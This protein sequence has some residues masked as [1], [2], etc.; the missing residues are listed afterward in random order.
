MR[1]SKLPLQDI[2]NIIENG[3]KLNGT[4]D[5]CS[6]TTKIYGQKV[7]RAKAHAKRVAKDTEYTAAITTYTWR[8][9]RYV[10]RRRS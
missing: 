1:L 8:R 6:N 2:S 9:A 7:S 5:A 4:C 3:V 10:I